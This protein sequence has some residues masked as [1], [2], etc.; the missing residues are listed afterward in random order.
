MPNS[1]IP[2][3][4]DAESVAESDA[5]SAAESVL[6]ESADGALAKARAHLRSS[7]TFGFAIALPL[8]ARKGSSRGSLFDSGATH[9]IHPTDEGAIEG[10]WQ[11]DVP[12][13]IIGDGKRLPCFGSVLVA[14]VPPPDVGGPDIIRRVLIAPRVFTRV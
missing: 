2:S 14:F 6:V 4:S 11:P 8:L 10:S 3:S 13:V 9:F 1:F 12:Y 5:E 7:R